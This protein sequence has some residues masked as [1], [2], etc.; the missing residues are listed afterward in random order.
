MSSISL[1]PHTYRGRGAVNILLYEVDTACPGDMEGPEGKLGLVPGQSF[2]EPAPFLVTGVLV[3]GTGAAPKGTAEV[4]HC[5]EIQGRGQIS[6]THRPPLCSSHWLGAQ[7]LSSWAQLL[8]S[9]AFGAWGGGGGPRPA[10][11][12]CSLLPCDRAGDS[13]VS[14]AS[15]GAAEQAPI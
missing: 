2:P 7:N 8:G 6:P 14:G 4:E 11:G 3:L 5:W 10:W 1:D 15:L 12:G 13:R 9:A